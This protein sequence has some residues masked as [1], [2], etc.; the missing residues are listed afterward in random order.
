MKKSHLAI[1]FHNYETAFQLVVNSDE[2]AAC[3]IHSANVSSAE[4]IS[5]R[6]Y[7]MDATAACTWRA[8]S[9]ECGHRHR[10]DQTHDPPLR[11]LVSD[12]VQGRHQLPV[13]DLTKVQRSHS[14]LMIS[15][16]YMPYAALN[17]WIRF[18][19][20]CRSSFCFWLGRCFWRWLSW[21]R[22]LREGCREALVLLERGAPCDECSE[23]CWRGY[24]R[25]FRWPCQV[26]MPESSSW[27][28]NHVIR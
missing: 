20:S 10:Q 24:G 17:Q 5:G 26:V 18:P 13:A 23:G 12:R 7:V 25:G 1:W 28:L 3:F 22:I 14:L 15:N 4:V 27:P 9:C 11:W 6:R 21:S 8:G 2:P 16:C 19:S